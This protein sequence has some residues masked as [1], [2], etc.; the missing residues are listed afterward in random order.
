MMIHRLAGRRGDKLGRSTVLTKEEVEFPVERIL[1][2]GEWGFPHGKRDLTNIIKDYLD[3]Q[4]RTTR[5]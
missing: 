2:M 1:V 5:R 4:G 3:H